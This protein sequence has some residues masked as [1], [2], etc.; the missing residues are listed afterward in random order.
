VLQPPKVKVGKLVTVRGMSLWGV[1]LQLLESLIN[2]VE[3][4][5]ERGLGEC[6]SLHQLPLHGDD[7]V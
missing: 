7:K 5:N 2:Y 3:A 1:Q 4:G 6:R